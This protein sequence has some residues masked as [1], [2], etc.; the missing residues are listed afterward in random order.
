ML[1]D[2]AS[3]KGQI[4]SGTGNL[5]ATASVVATLMKIDPQPT[6]A[7]PRLTM[8]LRQPEPVPPASALPSARYEAATSTLR[9]R[10]WRIEVAYAAARL[11]PGNEAALVVL[12]DSLEYEDPELTS[13][14]AEQRENLK[15]NRPVFDES[16]D[17]V[18]RRG[19]SV[20][21]IA[22]RDAAVREQAA[23]ALQLLM[24]TL[25]PLMSDANPDVVKRIASAF[26]S[27][28][29]NAVPDLLSMMRRD[30]DPILRRNA[31]LA[32]GEVGAAASTA[33]E[34][35]RLLREDEDEIVRANADSML[36]K[37]DPG[38]GRP[39]K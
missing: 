32:L 35:L 34:S 7:L 15:H 19:E 13:L 18:R 16:G 8:A 24:P 25:V 31:I 3:R 9:W 21:V 22:V 5:S 4:A 14:S 28:G 36:K 10:I 11:D 37:L 20:G 17:F 30:R 23:R 12:L 1:L 27:M 2:F 6:E 29:A 38:Y 33:V 39:S 26:Q